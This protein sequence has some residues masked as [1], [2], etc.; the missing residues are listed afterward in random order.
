MSFSP[1]KSSWRVFKALK[2]S[3]LS[4]PTELFC[5]NKWLFVSA[6]YIWICFVHISSMQKWLIRTFSLDVFHSLGWGLNAVTEAFAFIL[7]HSNTAG[8]FAQQ[9]HPGQ[10]QGY[11]KEVLENL[12]ADWH[13]LLALS[14]GAALCTAICCSLFFNLP[15]RCSACSAGEIL[16]NLSDRLFGFP[17]H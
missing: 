17:G 15:S 4:I 8:G 1:S 3:K 13:I 6:R 7:E 16:Q 9:R 5:W 12:F 11:I 14:S 2:K 10:T